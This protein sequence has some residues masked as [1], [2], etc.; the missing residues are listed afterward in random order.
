[1]KKRIPLWVLVCVSSFLGGF[2]GQALFSRDAATAASAANDLKQYYDSSGRARL[3][4]GVYGD[5]PM[6]DFYGEDGKL[7]I[8]MGTY[9]ASGEKGLPLV[10]LSDNGGNIRLLL[11]LAGSKEAPLVIF[12]DRKHQDRMIIGLN[13]ESEEPFFTYTD[14]K[15]E[16][17]SLLGKN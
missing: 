10:A 11:R 17:H 3:D 12:K 16:S 1:M 6:Q 2:A 13:G 14:S 5:T 9:T 7:R 4:L 8:Q 15:G